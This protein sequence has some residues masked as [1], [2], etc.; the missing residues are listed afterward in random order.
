MPR[1]EDLDLSKEVESK[2]DYNESIHNLQIELLHYQRKLISSKRALLLAFEGPDAA[3]KGGTIKRATEMLDPRYLRVHPIVK[4]TTEEYRHHYMWRF[5]NKLP[6]YGEITIFDRSW[7][8]RVLVERIESFCTE[9][10]WARAYDEINNFEGQLADDG[11]IILKFYLQISKE[12]QLR[13][14]KK[15]EADPLK[16]WK[17]SEED[18]R[19]RSRWNQYITAANDMFAKTNKKKAPWHL[20]EAEHKWYARVKTLRI[21]VRALQ[22][23]LG[24]I[25]LE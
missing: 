7:Y 20:I 6:A 4:P 16:R 21:I 18:W 3:G 15:R 24:P 22:K 17:M 25:S 23:E 13:R 8:G 19:N 14:F 2:S 11:M 10:E 12:E 1:L 9:E 5:W